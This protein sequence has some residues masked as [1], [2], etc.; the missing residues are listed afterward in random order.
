MGALVMLAAYE[1]VE[2]A[3][4]AMLWCGGLLI[5]L[6]AGYYICEGVAYLGRRWRNRD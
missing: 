5:A 1:C 2:S 4:M 3:G 6:A